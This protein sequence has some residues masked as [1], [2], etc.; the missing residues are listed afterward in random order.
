M[1]GESKERNKK[2]V[3]RK[4]ERKFLSRPMGEGH[5]RKCLSLKKEGA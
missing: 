1:N 2:K 3:G 5:G 4:V